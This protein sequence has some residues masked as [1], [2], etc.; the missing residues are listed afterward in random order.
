MKTRPLL[1][2]ALLL[3]LGLHVAFGEVDIAWSELVHAVLTGEGINGMH[4]TILREV[5][6]PRALTAMTSGAM[7]G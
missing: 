3:A 6:L 4:A 7:L 5:R 1:I 2:L